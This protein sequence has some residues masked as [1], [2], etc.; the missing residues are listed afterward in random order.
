MIFAFLVIDCTLCTS[1]DN[2]YNSDSNPARRRTITIQNLRTNS[3]SKLKRSMEKNMKKIEI[4]KASYL[5]IDVFEVDTK[6]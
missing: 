3:V 6:F 4:K 5:L 2:N 1:K